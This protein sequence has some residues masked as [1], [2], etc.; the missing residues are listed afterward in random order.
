MPAAIFMSW[1]LFIYSQCGLGNLAHRIRGNDGQR[2][3]M[4]MESSFSPSIF[5]TQCVRSQRWAELWQ[6]SRNC[7]LFPARR[8]WRICEPVKLLQVGLLHLFDPVLTPAPLCWGLAALKLWNEPLE[9]LVKA[10]VES[11]CEVCSWVALQAPLKVLFFL[12][13]SVP[14]VFLLGAICHH[15]FFKDETWFCFFIFFFSSSPWILSERDKLGSGLS[16]LHTQELHIA[17]SRHRIH[18]EGDERFQWLPSCVDVGL[19]L[20]YCLIIVIWRDVC[21]LANPVLD[22]THIYN[23]Q[24]INVQNNENTCCLSSLF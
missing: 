14:L 23:Q 22:M 5:H 10:T 20:F 11:S 2:M 3:K 4:Q 17:L 8:R 7:K 18:T 6:I 12:L 15:S 19:T 24:P 21:S 16:W 13:H 1:F 9:T